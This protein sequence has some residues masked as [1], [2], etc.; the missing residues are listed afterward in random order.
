MS[1]TIPELA[2]E[3][4]DLALAVYVEPL[5]SRRRVLFVGDASSPVPEHLA[6]VARTL[7][8]VTP[9]SRVRGA[10]RSDRG[11]TRPWPTE[12]DVGSWD[13]VLVPDLLGSSV[14]TSDR[15]E[16]LASWLAPGGVLVVG[17]E[18]REDGLSYE[19]LHGLLAGSFD[20]VRMLGQAPFAGWSI[21]DF[22]AVS[23]G[24]VSSGADVTF[25]G[26]LL[27][28]QG[29][30]AARF[31]GLC[32]AHDV[33]LDA[34]SVV[35][36]PA[37]SLPRERADRLAAGRDEAPA[38]VAQLEGELRERHEQMVQLSARAEEL[39]G[40]L[41]ASNARLAR[42]EVDARQAHEALA[43][44]GRAQHESSERHASQLEAARA[45]LTRRTSESERRREEFRALQGEARE[46]SARADGLRAEL[47]EARA[48]AADVAPAS[49]FIALEAAMLERAR[50]LT[51]LRG[52]VERR[53]TLVRD[54]VEELREARAR[55]AA[56]TPSAGVAR[57]ASDVEAALRRSLEQARRRAVEAEAAS[58]ELRFR[59]DES[60][61][62]LALRTQQF[63]VARAAS[64]SERA[65]LMSE[66]E[67][68][69]S[70]RAALMSERE[71]VT[72]EQAARG[73]LDATMRAWSAKVAESE[74]ALRVTAARL[75]LS[76]D[77]L[78]AAVANALRL[79]RA[80][81]E[82]LEQ[83]AL[84]NAR[85]GAADA[86]A[87][88][89]APAPSAH[90]VD[91]SAV[92]AAA[93]REALR[94][95]AASAREQAEAAV[96]ELVAQ[97]ALV[98]DLQRERDDAAAATTRLES[99]LV[100]S[101][102]EVRSAHAALDEACG[103][104][105]GIRLRWTDA[106][107]ALAAAEARLRPDPAAI[108]ATLR[109]ASELEDLRQRADVLAASLA[110]WTERAHA[111][112]A[113]V[114]EESRLGAELLGRLSAQESA[115]ERAQ[116]ALEA[117]AARGD[118]L[119]QSVVQ[120]EAAAVGAAE[121]LEAARSEAEA[122]AVEHAQE[123]DALEGRLVATQHA[124]VEAEQGHHAARMALAEARQSLADIARG[125]GVT[126]LGARAF[127]APDDAD[128]SE[129]ASPR[130]LFAQAR[131]G[132][133]GLARALPAEQ[134]AEA[135]DRIAGLLRLL[136]PD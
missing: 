56:V 2:R 127:A 22:G 50:E 114:E 34:Y 21:V 46:A 45:E 28:A 47:E 16:E 124:R 105:E 58:A 40:E 136:R 90:A 59:L 29:E 37:S 111:A 84:S 60:R 112:S 130:D 23:S 70:E 17:A 30:E 51:S 13:L 1:R 115:L 6:G 41:S 78:A 133:E 53:G 24:G 8:V 66:R 126:S 113:R 4:A 9:R 39:E 81:A 33:A 65:A 85:E 11:P 12:N 95:A 44:A 7:D 116:V 27:G 26:R 73:D 82:A 118:A 42:A 123:R 52:E 14:P 91:A 54:L 62:E 61:G 20:A 98:S 68:L 92:E 101:R 121:A 131:E 93:E 35:Q 49:E 67:A 96:A 71:A 25:D 89:E 125:M 119:Q 5:A 108:E 106:E 76:D 120:H 18:E 128:T 48:A 74:E 97:R 129:G 88:R 83:V 31:I 94:A 104:R 57:E 132:L 122:I 72:S 32:A 80:L 77:A 100:R 75:A 135:V 43:A 38:R 19:G 103:E 55:G 3:H 107:A 117:S 79:E 64:M 63:E 10:R 110:L 86:A 87:S 102:D 134:R 69:M 99:E 109:S 36:I 15:V